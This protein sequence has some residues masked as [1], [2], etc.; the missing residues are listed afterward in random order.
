[1]LSGPTKIKKIKIFFFYKKNIF[2]RSL[3]ITT[4]YGLFRQTRT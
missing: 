4:F 1:M 2:L 3:P